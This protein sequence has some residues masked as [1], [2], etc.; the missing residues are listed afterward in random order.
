MDI[1]H[2]VTKRKH[3]FH[4]EIRTMYGWFDHS[5]VVELARL[6]FSLFSDVGVAP[7]SN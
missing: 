5:H 3:F 7:G 4:V 6:Q 1:V 2:M